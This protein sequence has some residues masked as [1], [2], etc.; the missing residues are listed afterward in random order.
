MNTRHALFHRE[1][2]SRDAVFFIAGL[3]I[4]AAI[5]IYLLKS[6]Q[7]FFLF[8]GSAVEE[9]TAEKND[10]IQLDILDRDDWNEM[11]QTRDADSDT[12]LNTRF[13]SENS[14]PASGPEIKDGPEKT[15]AMD[16]PVFQDVEKNIRTL[17]R[18]PMELVRPEAELRPPVMPAQRKPREIVKLDESADDPD[19]TL[20]EVSMFEEKGVRVPPVRRIPEI[21]V[22][23]SPP[24]YKH[25][26]PEGTVEKV[27]E[28]S[29]EAH[30]NTYTRYYRKLVNKFKAV[31]YISGLWSRQALFKNAKG[32]IIFYLEISAPDGAIKV[33]KI[34]RNKNPGALINELSDIIMKCSPIGEFPEYIKEEKLFF[35]ITEVLD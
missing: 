17:P 28:A 1:S 4:S 26:N 23:V 3:L 15:A 5:H 29:F 10:A 34:E 27:D 35:R 16:G 11:V 6:E 30:E 2:I 24:Q 14:S 13:V 32:T 9:P 8:R 19:F 21:T 20:P 31:A 12:R 22:K 25:S 18:L 7:E 33:L